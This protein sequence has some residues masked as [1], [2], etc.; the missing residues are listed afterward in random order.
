MQ[1]FLFLSFSCFVFSCIIVYKYAN[2]KNTPLYILALAVLSWF[3][4]TAVIFLLPL[5]ISSTNFRACEG[6]NCSK[7]SGYLEKGVAFFYWRLLYWTLF[8]LTW[9]VVL[10]IPVVSR[11][12]DSGYFSSRSRLY[13]A[14]RSNLNHN[15]RIW[16]AGLICLIIMAIKGYLY[17][18]NVI[19][20][21][22]AVANLWGMFL[23]VSFMGVGLVEIPRKLKNCAN[24]AFQTR[25][26]ESNAA[27]IKFEV[28]DAELNVIDALQ[29]FTLIPNKN[30]ILSPNYPF[31][32]QIELENIDLLDFYRDK[33][34][35][36]ASSRNSNNITHTYLADLNR[37]IKNSAM[38]LKIS[39]YKWLASQNK[40][41]FYSDIINSKHKSPGILTSTIE[42]VRDWPI[43]RKRL[44]YIWYVQIAPVFF[45]LS[46]YIFAAL[47][48]IILESE[49]M[50]TI[51][52][53]LSII[54]MLFKYFETNLHIIEVI[55]LVLVAYMSIS[56]YTS[57]IKLKLFGINMLYPNHNSSPKS[58]LSAGCQLCRMM[59]PLCN[60]FLG[61]ASSKLKTE[62]NQ[63]MGKVDMVP[64]FGSSINK[65][66]ALMILLP[67]FLSYIRAYSRIMKLLKSDLVL[68][69][70]PEND[71]SPSESTHLG[72]AS[73]SSNILHPRSNE[74]RILLSAVYE[75]F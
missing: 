46:S 67:A 50:Q 74:G 72:S 10:Y 9:Y 6:S 68:D 41:F 32:L 19:A 3:P 51:F 4:P 43:W 17:P 47:S 53:R 14:F 11:F 55:S 70:E 61:L 54:G 21:V 29:E 44:E 18:T 31:I 16:S 34:F 24:S 33:I 49:A 64:I 60:N 40:Y 75:F 13:N 25:F 58:L 59:I 63:L 56:I 2:H 37:K 12:V 65:W 1:L 23:I 48:F 20:F 42:P 15:L 28:D 73:Q 71:N 22:M 7:P 45:L 62:F 26:I 39:E 35:Y 30:D 38:Q 5:D 57:L 8:V 27:D 69:Y 36:D 66:T 52:P